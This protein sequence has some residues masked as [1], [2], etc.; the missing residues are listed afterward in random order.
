MATRKK[1]QPKSRIVTRP[2]SAAPEKRAMGQKGVE[3]APKDDALWFT[4]LRKHRLTRKRLQPPLRAIQNLQFSSWYIERVPEILWAVLI[5]SATSRKKRMELLTSV[6]QAARESK[7]TTI[8]INHSDLAALNTHQFLHIFR[9]VLADTDAQEALRPL[10]VIDCLPDKK[11]WE[12]W[13]SPPDDQAVAWHS[14][15]SALIKVVDRRSEE[16]RNQLTSDGPR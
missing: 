14:L 11:H 5:A 1:K 16:S 13:I 15:A 4:P 12:M 8:F 9:A 7:D 3:G 10:L 2:D 6:C